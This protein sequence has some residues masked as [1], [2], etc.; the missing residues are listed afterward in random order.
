MEKKAEAY[1][2]YNNAA[3]AEMLIRVL[4]EIAGEIARPLSQ[5]DKITI[6]G[7]ADQENGV[8]TIASN[9][10]V[11]MSKLFESMKETTG[12]DLGEIMRAGTYDAKVNRNVHVTGLESCGA[13]QAKTSEKMTDSDHDPE[14]QET[15]G[16]EN[17]S[18]SENGTRA[19][20]QGK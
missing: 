8:S 9:V 20:E 1:Q 3:I 4:P 2:K 5:I 16:S 17:G 14:K 15:A 19:K 7:G 10:P 11:V 6:I 13:G 18:V 12:I